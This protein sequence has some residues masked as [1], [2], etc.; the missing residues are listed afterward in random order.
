ME[1]GA[2]LAP[3]S[4]LL[5]AT[6]NAGKVRELRALLADA[7]SALVSPADIGLS[8][9]V[10]ETGSTFIENARIKARA[11][12]DA[13]ATR[14]IAE[15]SGIEIDALGGEP[16]VYS[17]RYHG[18]PDGPIKNAHI[19]DLLADVE[20]S[21]RN[22]RYVCAIVYMDESGEE[23]VFEGECRGSIAAAPA[24]N[25]GFGF[26]PIVFLPRLGRT[27]AELTEDEKNRISHRGRAARR[28]LRF[29]LP[30]G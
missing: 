17:A 21:R 13:A 25:G 16:G 30:A 8:L 23:H 15:D 9:A 3:G 19:L 1:T 7:A 5:I 22:C 14:T 4:Q 18:L 28:F 27:M 24:G 6:T 29:L 2:I 20:P 26:D 10:E 11:Y 12:F